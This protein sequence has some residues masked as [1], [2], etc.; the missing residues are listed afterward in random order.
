MNETLL[1]I[2]LDAPFTFHRQ[3][4]SIASDLRPMRRLALTLLILTRSRGTKT[5]LLRLQYIDWA[6]RDSWSAKLFKSVL[7]GTA[8]PGQVRF[9]PDPALSRAVHMGIAE[10]LVEM[11]GT[12][13]KR[14]ALT[15]EG[16]S[17]A[18]SIDSHPDLFSVE[19]MFLD[20]IK[21]SATEESVSEMGKR[22]RQV[23][24]QRLKK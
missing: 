2:L 16:K 10:G 13:T 1:D 18:K 7:E 3:P 12:S 14:L 20:A 23:F 5:S 15:S 6:I 17:T 22:A 24:E 8:A 9:Q 21:S 19:R 4:V 11:S